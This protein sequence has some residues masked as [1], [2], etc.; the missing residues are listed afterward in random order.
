MGSIEGHTGEYTSPFEIDP[1]EVDLAEK[2]GFLKEVDDS[3]REDWIQ[4]RM[5]RVQLQRMLIHFWSSEG[6]RTTRRLVNAFAHMTAMALDS[7]S[8]MQRRSMSLYCDPQEPGDGMLTNPAS[9]RTLR[10]GKN[11]LKQ[12]IPRRNSSTAKGPL[13]FFPARDTYRCT[14][15]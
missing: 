7:D 12:V 4:R 13:S 11:E 9:E 6:T 8:Q 15:P 2:T 5:I 10:Q 1:I 14:K 3:L